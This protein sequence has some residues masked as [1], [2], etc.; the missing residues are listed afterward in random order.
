MVPSVSMTCASTASNERGR[1]GPRLGRA[2][3]TRPES[4]KAVASEGT[5]QLRRVLRRLLQRSIDHRVQLVAGADVRGVADGCSGARRQQHQ[6]QHDLEPQAHDWPSRVPHTAD[7]V[8]QL[9]LA[10]K[11]ELAAQVGDVDGEVLAV[12][13]E[14]VAPDPV[15]D[16]RVVEHDPLVAQQQL[17]QVELGLRQLDL[18]LDPATPVEMSGR[19][20]GR[21]AAPRRCRCRS[22]DLVRRSRARNRANSSSRSNGLA[23]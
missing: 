11:F 16:G 15:V 5:Q 23:R 18:A 2:A 9:G 12:G 13:P 1:A 3:A 14:V 22:S 8:D 17:E 20:A 21:R 6:R 19:D 4:R 10:G 7:G